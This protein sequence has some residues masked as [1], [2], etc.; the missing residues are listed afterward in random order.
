ML[1]CALLLVA[2]CGKKNGN[3]SSG[4]GVDAEA[5]AK[6]L[7]NYVYK[8]EAVG[9]SDMENVNTNI[10]ANGKQYIMTS[11]WTYPEGEE[12]IG[13]PEAKTFVDTAVEESAVEDSS[14]EEDE[15]LVE[16]L[17]DAQ[18]KK[19]VVEEPLAVDEVGDGTA[20]DDMPI[21][22]VE[23]EG[24]VANATTKLTIS[25]NTL[26]GKKEF[27]YTNEYSG[28]YNIYYMSVGRSGDVYFITNT[29]G[30]EANDYKEEYFANCLDAAGQ[31]KWS[32]AL[33]GA[34]NEG[35]YYYPSKLLETPDGLAVISNLGVELIDGSG[36]SAGLKKIKEMENLG[37]AFL[38]KDG[39]LA[40]LVYGDTDAELY[41]VDAKN[42]KL[43]EKIAIP[44]T[45]FAYNIYSGNSVYDLLLT[46]QEGL[47]Y[48]NI[49]DAKET[50]FMD[51]VASDLP[52]TNIQDISMVDENTFYGSYYSE[53]DDTYGLYKFT[54]VDPSTVAEKKIITLGGLWIDGN[55][56]KNA[57]AFNKSSDEYR[58]VLKDY[59]SESNYAEFTELLQTVNNDIITGKMPDIMLLDSSLN[60]QNY[61]AKG[62]FAELDSYIDADPDIKR[63]DYLA[64]VLNAVSYDG[65]MY[66]LVPS[67]SVNT[68]A[69]KKSIIGDKTRWNI[70]EFTQFADSIDPDATLMG[71]MTKQDFVSSMMYY[72]SDD[73]IDKDT[74]QAKFDSQEFIDVLK[75][76]ERY[77]VEIDYNSFDDE[78][79]MEAET[80]Y[81]ENKAYLLRTGL[82][83]FRDTSNQIQGTM[84]EPVTYIGY[85]KEEGSGNSI[86]FDICLAIN[87]KSK[88]KDAAWAYIRKFMMDDYQE[89][90][91]YTFP[92]KKSALEKKAK[93]EMKPLTY[94]DED[95]SEVEYKDSFY[96]GNMIIEIDPP[97]QAEVDQIMEVLESAESLASYN[98]EIINIIAE[99]AQ[100]YYNGQKSAEEVAKIIQGRIQIYLNESR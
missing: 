93:N 9:V 67:F 33:T 77:P 70:G 46:N 62:V 64:N 1:L 58:I 29:Y 80:F 4:G 2:G 21:D 35:E 17:D 55:A 95:G 51:Y 53:D 94:T 5:M 7:T 85:P 15:S 56:R 49:G 10:V 69:V 72:C 57:V 13:I 18:A 6:E 31:E 89:S 63:E 34:T 78:Y 66:G 24:D 74:N 48:Y 52:I 36:N 90:N 73:F 26:D 59:S 84:G 75:F 50:K 16:D 91:L 11:E 14:S 23:G 42:G 82:Y 92:I 8:S 39:R 79:W 65:K 20:S 19:L 44:F 22:Y 54:K 83:N 41:V 81:R 86:N 71:L 61:L 3:S 47:F 96:I 28:D 12:E 45:L 100:G 88:N 87:N 60:I 32:T 25:C 99:E 97:T 40:A 38:L 30:N 43:G 27:E 98:D 37:D 76:V 68:I